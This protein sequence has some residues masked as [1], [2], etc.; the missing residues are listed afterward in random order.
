L[1]EEYGPERFPPLFYGYTRMEVCG[2]TTIGTQ[3]YFRVCVEHP[4]SWN[5]LKEGWFLMRNDSSRI[6]IYQTA[7]EEEYLLYVI[8]LVP[9]KQ[10]Q[11]PCDWARDSLFTVSIDSVQ[12]FT[13]LGKERK[14][15]YVTIDP[16]DFYDQAGHFFSLYPV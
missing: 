5:A 12:T 2:D 10:Y 11:F 16:P 13:I 8:Y 15:Q 1:S 6:Y 14:I 4:D 7:W 3:A 9:G